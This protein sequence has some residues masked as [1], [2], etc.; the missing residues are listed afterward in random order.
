MNLFDF[1]SIL[2]GFISVIVA[3]MVILG[4]TRPQG[5][6]GIHSKTLANFTAPLRKPSTFGKI[7][8][9]GLPVLIFIVFSWWGGIAWFVASFLAVKA[10]RKRSDLASLTST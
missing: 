6:S 7:V 4:T 3:A 10:N 8:Y 2:I 9:W 1:G 5:D